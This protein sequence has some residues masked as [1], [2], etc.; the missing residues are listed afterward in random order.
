M[1]SG[2]NLMRSGVVL[3]RWLICLCDE[4]TQGIQSEVLF[5][6]TGCLLLSPVGLMGIESGSI[7]TLR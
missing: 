1:L 3:P 5:T 2:E 4:R 6:S 7:F